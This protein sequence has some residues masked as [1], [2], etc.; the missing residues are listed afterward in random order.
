MKVLIR[1]FRIFF[2]LGLFT[3]G[4]GFAMIPLIEE[5]II[6]KNSM[7]KEDEFFDIIA[8][9]QSLP[10]S[11]AVNMS[12]FIGYHISGIP[13]A[14]TS[15][16]AVVIPPFTVILLIASFFVRFLEH[17]IA[18][19]AFKGI[20]IAVLVLIL[21]ALKRLAQKVH[22][23]ILKVVLVA[24]IIVAISNFGIHPGFVIL[25]SAALGYFVFQPMEEKEG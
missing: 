10:G 1:L 16:I 24:G 11:L 5:E 6:K 20:R 19:Q 21:L 18:Q 8:F 23:N 17:P 13:G 2:R 14:L 15:S 25:L 22:W 4:G 3:F 12:I 7:L 9:T